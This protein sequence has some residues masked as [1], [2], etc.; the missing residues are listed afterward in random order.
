MQYLQFSFWFIVIHTV[1][2]TAAG[3]I[4]LQLSKELYEEKNRL[5]DYLRDMSDPA[6]SGHVSKWFIPAQLVRGLLLS[7]VL[8]PILGLL[9]ELSFALRFLFLAGL[10]F[11]YTDL[12]AAVPFSHNIEKSA[13]NSSSLPARPNG[14][15]TTSCKNLPSTLSFGRR[16]FPFLTLY[17]QHVRKGLH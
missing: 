13:T 2:Y 10:M 12:A 14:T 7:I 5:L 1:A 9:G 11:V 16:P 3:A 4:A 6:E 8:Y 17:W 15:S